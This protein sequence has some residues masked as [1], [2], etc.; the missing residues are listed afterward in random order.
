MPPFNDEF[1]ELVK[2]SPD[3]YGPFWIMTTIV[4]LLGMVGNFANYMLSKFSDDSGFDGY[5]FRLELVR[6]AVAFVYSFAVGVPLTLWLMFKFMKANEISLA[7]VSSELF[8]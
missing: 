7:E 6:Y 1:I 4:F 3:L 5:F 2:P 8:S